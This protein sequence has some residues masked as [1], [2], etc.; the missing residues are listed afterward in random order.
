MLSKSFSSWYFLDSIKYCIAARELYASSN[1]YY[2]DAITYF[3]KANNTAVDNYVELINY[4]IKVSDIAIDINWA[5][6][7]ACEYFESASKS[8]HNGYYETD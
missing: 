5:M 3:E 4:Y 1:L 2:Q 7:E 8:Y 6:Y